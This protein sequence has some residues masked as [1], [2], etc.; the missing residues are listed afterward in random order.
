M[1]GKISD[2][3]LADQAKRG[4]HAALEKLIERYRPKLLPFILERYFK[5]AR[6][7]QDLAQDALALTFIRVWEHISKFD[8]ALGASFTTWVHTIAKN[9]CRDM[10]KPDQPHR[11]GYQVRNLD[12][13]DVDDILTRREDE[14]WILYSA[15]GHEDDSIYQEEE[16][17]YEV[18]KGADVDPFLQAKN[19][20]T[21]Q[22]MRKWDIFRG[23]RPLELSRADR[24]WIGK[25]TRGKKLTPREEIIRRELSL[26]TPREEIAEMAGISLRALDVTICRLNKG[27]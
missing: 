5:E 17:F 24:E 2:E 6:D 11:Q 8:P 23:R 27:K 15:P 19:E 1:S 20:K 18:Y 4:N 16:S 7:A 3:V 9:V 26:G 10:L 25:T 14:E 21:L 22:G 13:P 12:D